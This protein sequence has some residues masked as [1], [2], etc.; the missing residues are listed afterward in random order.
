[1]SV[2]NMHNVV[3]LMLHEDA[4]LEPIVNRAGVHAF[5][6]PAAEREQQHLLRQSPR[7]IQ[8]RLSDVRNAGVSDLA[9]SAV[10]LADLP[11]DAPSIVDST[12]EEMRDS[13]L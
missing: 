4:A 13:N 12:C 6:M 8:F 9:A 3:T 5:Q 1:M 10:Q 11:R 2:L 7:S